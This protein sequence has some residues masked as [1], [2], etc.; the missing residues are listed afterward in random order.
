[1]RQ[2]ATTVMIGKMRRGERCWP[3]E[4]VLRLGGLGLLGFCAL[5]ARLV[6]HHVQATVID[7]P[8]EFVLSALAFCCLTSGLALLL[9]GPRLFRLMP[10]PPRA[11]LP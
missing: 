9:F 1:M 10:R 5:L 3:A 2:N 7:T 8:P 11:L 6:V 4:F